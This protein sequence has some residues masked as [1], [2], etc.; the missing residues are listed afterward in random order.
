M[1]QN[2]IFRS[3]LIIANFF[4]EASEIFPVELESCPCWY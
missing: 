1:L 4:T 3:T 2:N